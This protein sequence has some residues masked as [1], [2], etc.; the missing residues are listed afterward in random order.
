MTLAPRLAMVCWMECDEP[1]PISI[2]AMTAAMPMMMP[3]Q[4]S[5]DR[6]TLRRSACRAVRMMR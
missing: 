4:V 2:M 3:R 6:M 5:T 1:R